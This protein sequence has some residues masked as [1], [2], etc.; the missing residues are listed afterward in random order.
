ME[1]WPRISADELKTFL[2][3]HVDEFAE[4]M[5]EAVNEAAPGR[6][7]ADSEERAREFILEFGRSAYEAL[8]Q[9]KIDAAEASFSPSGGDGGGSGGKEAGPSSLSE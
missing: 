5:V 8:L 7:I 3:A 2:H 4:R 9:Q 6:L 1:G